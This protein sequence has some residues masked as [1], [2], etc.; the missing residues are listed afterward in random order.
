MGHDEGKG[1]GLTREQ[2]IEALA[3]SIDVQIH[4]SEYR[5]KALRGAAEMVWRYKRQFLATGVLDFQL[6]KDKFMP[7]WMSVFLAT[8]ES[9]PK[10][11]RVVILRGKHR[12]DKVFRVFW[13]AWGK[14]T[15]RKPKRAS[16]RS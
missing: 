9:R 1:N 12:R 16:M 4:G 11:W 13:L 14:N 7:P 3:K 6:P 2:A 8:L 5:A 10:T 15:R